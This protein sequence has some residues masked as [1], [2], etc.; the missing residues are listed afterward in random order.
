[1]AKSRERSNQTLATIE[2]PRKALTMLQDAG[3]ILRVQDGRLRAAPADSLGFT[4]DQLE[5]LKKHRDALKKLC[6]WDSSVAVDMLSWVFKEIHKL[7]NDEDATV[8]L[9]QMTKEAIED[10]QD[11]AQMG[12]L[13]R[14]VTNMLR[15]ARRY[16]RKYA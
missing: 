9:I 8:T 10:A 2:D 13:R 5:C 3:V 4:D 14:C 11:N 7:T 12:E 16:E 1:M 6:A 15:T